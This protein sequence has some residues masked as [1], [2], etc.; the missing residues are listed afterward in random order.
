MLVGGNPQQLARSERTLGLASLSVAF[1]QNYIN[2]D[3]DEVLWRNGDGIVTRECRRWGLLRRALAHFD[4]VHFN[5]GLSILPHRID[6]RPGPT[7]R[8]RGIARLAYW[9]YGRL[10]YLK[11]LPLLRRAGKAVFVTYQGDDA[12]QSDYCR[13]HFDIHFADEVPAGYYSRSSDARKRE[14]IAL[15]SRYADGIFALNP[16][17][18]HVLPA[19]ARFMPY[20]SVDLDEWRPRNYQTGSRA[21]PLV[22]HAPSHQG[23]KGTRFIIEAVDRLRAVGVEFDFLLVEGVSRAQARRIYEQADLLV[24]QLLSGWY[25]GVAVEMM[26]LGKPVVCYLRESDLGY[27]DPAMR[28]DLPL[29]RATPD[30]VYLTLHEL[31]VDRRDQLA[32]LGERSRRFVETWHDP[33]KIAAQLKRQY[34][35]AFSNHRPDAVRQ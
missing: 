2:Y 30:T 22:I 18:L 27:L 19:G 25:G 8:S 7:S 6:A 17:L 21:R 31:L 28:R 24:D 15:F 13:S 20:A 11:D 10:F 14:E 9:A 23:V 26:A 16:D 5:C 32:H 12:R 4:V 3:C 33:R 1:E 35:A 29:V 34:E